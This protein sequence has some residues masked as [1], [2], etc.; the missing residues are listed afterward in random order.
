MRRTEEDRSA[1][2]TVSGIVPAWPKRVQGVL[3]LF[4]YLP[5]SISFS[6]SFSLPLLERRASL[7]T[8]NAKRGTRPATAVTIGEADA[9]CLSSLAA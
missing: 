1:C 5:F 8:R 7:V 2:E 6:I 4:L 3:S 9:A